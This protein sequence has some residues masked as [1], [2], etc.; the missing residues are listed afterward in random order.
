MATFSDKDGKLAKELNEA[1]ELK[2]M[3]NMKE[4]K[5]IVDTWNIINKYDIKGWEQ[6]NGVI[7]I[8]N[9][10]YNR[11]LNEV[12]NKSYLRNLIK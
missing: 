5:E 3:K 2:N 8:P 11:V 9:E 12:L 1:Y 6:G 7:Y 4:M 10:E